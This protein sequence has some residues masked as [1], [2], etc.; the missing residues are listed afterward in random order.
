MKIAYLSNSIIPSRTANSINVVRMCNAFIEAGNSVE[1]YVPKE[2]KYIEDG[3]HDVYRFYGIQN[4]F[5][6]LRTWLPKIMGKYYFYFLCSTIKIRNKKFDIVYTRSILGCFFAIAFKIDTV[7]ELHEPRMSRIEKILFNIISRSKNFR[8]LIVLC[9]ELQKRFSG[10]G[11]LKNKIYIAHD[12]AEI[13]VQNQNCLD[14]KG[15]SKVLK[16]GYFGHLYKGRGIDLIVEL[17]KACNFADFHI[18]GGTEEDKEKW[19]R[20]SRE[21]PNIFFYGFIPPVDIYTYQTEM[22]IL[23]APYSDQVAV[24]GGRGNS[25]KWMS[26]L[27]IFEYMASRKAIIVSNLPSLREVLDEKCAVLCKPNDFHDWYEAINSL[28]DKEI[29]ESLANCAYEKFL[30]NH[31]WKSRAKTVLMGIN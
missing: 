13:G 14:L 25:S 7:L 30:N 3:I 17:A 6:I 9:G 10:C 26:P 5:P 28:R 1:L 20:K 12:A 16:I 24:S 4:R 22:D 18:I 31:T 21:I 29:R 27:K 19:E 23:L 11:L 2:N 15:R 8:R